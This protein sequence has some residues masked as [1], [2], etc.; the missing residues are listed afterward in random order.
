MDQQRITYLKT[1]PYEE[2]LKTPEWKVKRAQRLAQDR[3]RCVICNCAE[4][5]QVH[6]RTY[7]RRGN[8]LLEDL[9]TLCDNCHE[10]H[11][12]RMQM[13]RTV[14]EVIS[15]AIPLSEKK[16]ET[17]K[18]KKI[19]LE[20]YL[21][22]LLLQH[23]FLVS[24]VYTIFSEEDF[25]Q[26][27]NRAVYHLMVS[28]LSDHPVEL[29]FPSDLLSVIDR[30]KQSAD[31]SQLKGLPPVTEFQLKKNAI[32][33]AIRIKRAKLLNENNE[34]GKAIKV[35][36]KAHEREEIRRLQIQQLDV[37]QRLR[38]LSIAMQSNG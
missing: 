15:Q 29:F 10:H 21:L 18:L 22:G 3:N 17:D 25:L 27:D 38:T 13:N 7:V 34:I 30:A 5:L 36:D 24:H 26:E 1:M 14:E 23:P 20:D 8:E 32:Q 6:H 33:C 28:S 2:Y 37:C 16:Q 12:R 35:A 19:S 4:K 9:T 31:A 11:H